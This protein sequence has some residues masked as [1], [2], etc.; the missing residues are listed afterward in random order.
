M[1]H[2]IEFP[3]SKKASR[4]SVENLASPKGSSASPDLGP[5]SP[6]S[7]LLIFVRA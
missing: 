6:S 7:N 4:A 3:F 1:N 2:T 5:P